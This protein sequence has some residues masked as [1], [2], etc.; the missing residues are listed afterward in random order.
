[1]AIERKTERAMGAALAALAGV[2]PEIV[3][4]GRFVRGRFHGLRAE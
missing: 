3:R 2:G 4:S 1:M